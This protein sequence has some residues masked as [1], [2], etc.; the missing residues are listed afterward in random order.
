MKIRKPS[1]VLP[2]MGAAL[3]ALSA[4]GDEAG[5]TPPSEPLAPSEMAAVDYVPLFAPG[6]QVMEQIQY[7]EADGTLVTLAGFRPTN[8]H[9]RERGEPWTSP[10]V[11]PGNYF[12]FPTWYFQNRTFGLMIR[13]GVPAGR[14]RIEISLR[15]ND[16]T[17]VETGL[18]AFRRVD[19][20]IRDY[21]W[22]MN[23]GFQNPK[24]GNKNICHATS[25]REDCMA[26]ITDNWRA[27]Q[28]G[29]PLK[30]GDVIEVTPAPYLLHTLDNKAVIDGGG[31]RYYSF[32]Q[33]YQVGVGMRPWYG[34][35]PTLD[36]VPLPASTLLGGEASV[37]YN[38]SEEP[39]RVF[40][41]TVNNI[42]ISNMKRFVEGRR[43]FHTSFVDGKHSESPDINPVFT[44]HANQLG[45]R[46]NNVSCIS[47]HALNGR[48]A[49][50][51]LGA[52]LDT[53]AIEAA[54]SSSA[55]QVTPDPTYGLNVQQR[56]LS[57]G[58]ADYAVSVQSYVKTVRTLPDGET[59]ELQKPVYAFKGPVPAQY[60]VRQA[61]QVMGVGL[62]EA[63]D[64]AALLA[65]SDPNDS[66]GDGVKGVPNWVINP[67]TGSRHLGRFGWKA[68][69]ASLR[70]QSGDALLKD[71]GV[72]SPVY[73]SLTC[74]RGVA[75][76]NASGTSPSISETE[77]ERLASYLALLGVPA[78][79]SL[80]SGF[81]DGIRVSPEHDVNPTLISRGSTLFTQVKC[82]TCHT[83]EMKTGA[84]HPFAE[85]RHQTIHPYSNLMLHDL[86]PDLADT[87]TQGQAG[88][89]LWRTAP[90]WGIGSLKYVQGGAQNVRYLHDGRARTLMEAIAWHG[91]EANASRVQFEALSKADR[92]A[93]LA[94]LE[95]L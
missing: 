89:R 23:V 47:C 54:A 75:N 8:R 31:I 66:N 63:M 42:G 56:A 73:K 12:T 83:P 36:S 48:S 26:V 40:Q 53:L 29:T 9:A 43:L 92:T 84:N 72:T 68:S 20:D 80:R 41:Q 37:S 93:V 5:P 17:F 33:L 24:E 35:A 87:L 76:C 28:P 50:P 60:S 22:K 78:Q 74:Q 21:G 90:L 55:T 4:C 7:K 69:K 79:R 15:V 10:D 32:E 52:R 59:V 70:Q 82:G 94:F 77:I 39:H 58:G 81:M 85:L 16:G 19:P 2:S 44:Q 49:V 51:T 6:T 27:P 34:V 25:V 67:E 38:Y 57:A 13:D 1:A 3:L 18:S 62:L 95:S 45:P 71:M 14:S 64:E 86:G 91:G 88:P 11:G 65:L 61:P 46:F 30:V